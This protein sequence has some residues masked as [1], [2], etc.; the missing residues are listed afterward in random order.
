[1]ATPDEMKRRL[2][3]KRAVVQR[4]LAT[5]DGREL[6]RIV[7]QEFFHK[8]LAG[9]TPEEMAFNLGACDVIAFLEQLNERVA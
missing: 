8:R 5:E 1:M 3:A 7:K 2:E 6:L 4:V 9:K